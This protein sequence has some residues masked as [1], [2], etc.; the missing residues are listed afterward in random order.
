[1][2]RVQTTIRQAPRLN[3]TSCLD[4]LADTHDAHSSVHDGAERDGVM[5]YGRAMPSSVAPHNATGSKST[6]C[7]ALAKRAHYA[8]SLVAQS[9][10]ALLMA[11][12]IPFT[13]LSTP[14]ASTP[15]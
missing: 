9:L 3:D 8:S 1:V 15:Q 13:A 5:R 6:L 12:A 14:A 11:P 10:L 4:L 7:D 2:T